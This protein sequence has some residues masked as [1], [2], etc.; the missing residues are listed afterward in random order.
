[1]SHGLTDRSSGPA[2][3][4]GGHGPRLPARVVLVPDVVHV[5][6]MRLDRTFEGAI[7]LLNRAERQRAERLV[8]ESDQRRFINAHALLRAILGRCLD[9]PPNSLRFTADDRGKP[10]LHD[11]PVDLRF[12]L[13]HSGDLALVALTVG[14]EVGVDLEQYRPI[15]VL[16]LARH[17]F[18]E[19][20][21]SALEAL[22]PSERLPAFFRCWTRKEAFIKALGAG[23][24]FPLDDFDVDITA[25]DVPQ[26]L[27]ACRDLPAAPRQW[28]IVPLAMA[29]GY[30]AAL[31]AAEVGE[32]TVS[33][34]DQQ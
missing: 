13:S 7:D 34:W 9:R 31:A 33:R 26:V 14:R 30:A 1:M 22:A 20:E 12:N 17:F 16:D 5:V 4:D 11:P 2:D 27:R 3:H 23:L 8:F 15:E 19:S 29:P 10:R 25:D 28:R 32:W 18:A 21:R 6:Q 24:S